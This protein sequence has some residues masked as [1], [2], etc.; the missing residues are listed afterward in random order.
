MAG[1]KFGYHAL[2][3]DWHPVTTLEET[4]CPQHYHRGRAASADG[5]DSLP[6]EGGEAA[7]D[8]APV[9]ETAPTHHATVS[10]TAPADP[11]PATSPLFEGHRDFAEN[12]REV[13]FE[14]LLMPYLVG[15]EKMT[16]QDP[17]VRASHQGRNLVEL[18][19]AIASAKDPADNVTFVL[20][21]A[22]V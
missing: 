13:S 22:H 12:Q 4:E 5:R 14:S 9:P 21:T 17:N 20:I 3:G 15:A 1:V 2:T 10:A 7:A 11:E 19:A 18:L 8:P 16:L 6:G